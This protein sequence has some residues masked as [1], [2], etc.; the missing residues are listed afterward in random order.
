MHRRAADE[1]T[2]TSNDTDAQE[3]SVITIITHFPPPGVT[4]PRLAAY[5]KISFNIQNHTDKQ[6]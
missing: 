5:Q 2:R 4:P 6:T 3:I 1:K